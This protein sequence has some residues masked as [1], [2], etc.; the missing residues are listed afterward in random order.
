M[1]HK[2]FVRQIA[3][4]PMDDAVRSLQRTG[5]PRKNIFVERNF[6][7]DAPW[8]S[9]GDHLTVCSLRELGYGTE[10]LLANLARLCQAGITLRALDEPWYDLTAGDHKT[11][12]TGLADICR[13]KKNTSG[14]QRPEKKKR[15]GRPPG[16]TNT[17]EAKCRKCAEL[18]STT[19]RTQTEVLA[20]LHLSPRSWKNYMVLMSL[21]IQKR[22]K[23]PL[24]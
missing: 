24:K 13:T 14:L 21:Q 10:M 11:L 15:P 16:M 22:K 23:R 19:D 8:L 1:K 3:E 17:T 20:L 7:P 18:L 6:H 9:P 12:V 5:I 4:D 2:G